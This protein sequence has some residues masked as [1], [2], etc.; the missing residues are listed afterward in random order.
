MRRL[1]AFPLIA[2]LLAWSAPVVG[3]QEPSSMSLTLLAQT[4][5]ASLTAPGLDVRFRAANSGDTAADDL[6]IGV[7]LFGRVTSRTAYEQ[8]LLADP[9]PP[10]VIDGETL[11]REGTVEP[12][13]SRDFEFTLD[14]TFPG[15]D[16]SQPGVYPLK[17][18]LRSGG[19]PLAAI[20]TPV[21]F[22]VRTPEQPMT[23]S[24]VFVLHAPITFG[25]DGVFTSPMLEGSILPGGN[26][27]GEIRALASLAVETSIPVDV[28]ASPVL[29]NQ[30]ARMRDGYEVVDGGEVREVSQGTGGAAAAASAIESLRRIAAAPQ[31]ALSALPLSAPQVPS[32]LAAG[33]T[34]DLDVQLARG[35]EVVNALLAAT[36]DPTSLRPPGGALD[37][38]SV[39]A[40]DARGIGVLY[41]D[42][43][44]VEM[45]PQPLDFA[46]PPTAA[47]GP[48]GA[49]TAVVPDPA[50]ATLIASGAAF[51]DPILSAQ[52][53]LGELA[54]IWLER[55]G[56]ARGIAVLLPDGLSLPGAFFAPFVHGIAGAPWL[57]PVPASEL[58]AAF[59]PGEGS[60]AL[61]G[62]QAM[63]FSDPYIGQLRQA[64]RRID[65]YRSM[66]AEESD[67]PDRMETQLLLA[68]AGQYLSDPTGG[69]TFIDAV[70][71]E[72]GS[73]FRA[74]EPDAG[75]VITLTSSTGSRI[76][77]RVTNGTTER[78]HVAV[79]LV[80]Q[81]LR[82][83]P[84][85]DLTLDPGATETLTFDVDLKTTGRFP[86]QVQVVAPNGRVV[87]DTT[88]IVRSTAYS[89]LALIVTLLAALVLFAVWGRRFLP[90]RTT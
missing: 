15:I 58:A 70:R 77:V 20:R 2:V 80:S 45:P 83:S 34:G 30:L 79:R 37:D 71:D 7:T 88:V 10:V 47:V 90:R 9:E 85:S 72:V 16:T 4:P 42:A 25:P 62:P 49:V 81:H 26:L 86:V 55:P 32:L 56:E 33:M 17:V 35:S 29:L 27:A 18:E 14:L 39:E 57:D 28:V 12:G 52:S 40:L 51:D 78:M 3:A 84:S 50:V 69:L 66:L 63:T 19:V 53:A 75:Q 68:E 22:L 89:R 48:D 8:S 43:G 6:T 65:A 24:W 60:T 36:A 44:G 23:S 21:I 46:Q 54:T 5:W 67:E 31:V 59:P 74:V 11:F 61:T 76:P 41:P 13:A 38:A 82:E 1:A 64:R 87:N 73:I